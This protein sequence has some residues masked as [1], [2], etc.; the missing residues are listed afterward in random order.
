MPRYGVIGDVHGSA[1]A[2]EEV[3]RVFDRRAVD[4]LICVGDLVGFNAAGN[5][6]AARLA[7]SQAA[8][9]A[10]NHDRIALG[11]LDFGRCWYLVE[12][13]LGRTRQTLRDATREYLA[14]LPLVREHGEDMLLFHGALDDVER[15]TRSRQD[16]QH[17]D[18]LVRAGHPRARVCFYGHTH[19]AMVH[20]VGPDGRAERV[21]KDGIVELSDDGTRRWFVNPG[22]V[23]AARRD[24]SLAR[25][26]IYDESRGTVELLDVPY[27]K[28]ASEER[29]RADGYRVSVSVKLCHEAEV[30]AR[31]TAGG[32]LRVARSALGR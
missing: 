20:A 18:E 21:A 30:L 8:C 17:N 3:L 22:S 9:V 4:E 11:L 28:V 31:R 24:D 2:L 15:Y 6:V 10:G 29:A 1:E 23:D 5:E 26:A 14:S 32:L 13:A 12:H 27:D 7:R 25:M 19:K 16:V